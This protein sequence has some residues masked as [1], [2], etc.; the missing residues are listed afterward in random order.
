MVQRIP[1]L[2]P[3]LPTV[4]ELV[5]YLNIIFEGKRASNFGPLVVQ[6][7]ELLGEDVG[8]HV[9]TCSN[10]TVALELAIQGLDLH[11]KS[12]ILCPALTFPATA[13]AI[14]KAGH[15]PVFVDVH[16]RTWCIA[17]NELPHGG[18]GVSGG[19]AVTAYGRPYSNAEAS[20]PTLPLV[21]DAAPAYGNQRAISGAV[22]CYSLHAT[23][24]LS[25]GEG[26][27]IASTDRTIVD[28]FRR[29]SNFGL[30]GGEIFVAG[31]NAK[32]S[33]YAAASALASRFRWQERAMLRQAAA[34]RYRELLEGEIEDLEWQDWNDKWTRTIFP[35][36]LPEG[37]MVSKVVA[38]LAVDGVET[39]RWYTPLLCD[40]PAFRNFLTIG[41]LQH[42][43]NIASRLIGLPFFTGITDEQMTRVAKLL[44]RALT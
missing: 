30:E 21:V 3:D 1:L 35:V 36:L 8:G 11:P 12:K 16:P 14:L 40:M 24:T 32:M 5:P 9:A 37:V 29:L 39:R 41:G 13:T 19:V 31:T 15:E 33:E 18:Y 43:R 28:Y 20:H 4:E 34:L 6:L 17:A 27:A 42:S 38:K 44:R 26:G 10:G 2:T 22:V 7:E 25:A 23:K